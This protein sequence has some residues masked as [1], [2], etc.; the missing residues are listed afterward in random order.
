MKVQLFEHLFENS[1]LIQQTFCRRKGVAL[2]L[3]ASEGCGSK[4]CV[5]Y[6]SQYI[7]SGNAIVQGDGL[8][9]VITQME[10]LSKGAPFHG[11]M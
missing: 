10:T 11:I 7:L 9:G 4:P 8:Y 6:P 1:E 3:Q 2:A 5:I